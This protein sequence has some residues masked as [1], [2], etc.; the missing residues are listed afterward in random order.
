[1]RNFHCLATGVNVQPLAHALIRQSDLWNQNRIRT[2]FR[3]TPFA[4]IDDILLRFQAEPPDPESGVITASDLDCVMYPAWHA[5][6]QV[7]PLVMG[8]MAQVGGIRLGRV[9]ITRLA[10]GGR[11]LRHND[12]GSVY[13]ETYQRYH[14][15]VSGSPG[16][17]FV[18]GDEQVCMVTGDVWWANVCEEHECYNNSACDRVHLLIDVQPL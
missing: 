18:T 11:I 3:G 9:L 14:L 4:D 13:A 15:V 5:L 16:S 6:P 1:M 12:K 2:T 17:L 7:A 10:P 8:V